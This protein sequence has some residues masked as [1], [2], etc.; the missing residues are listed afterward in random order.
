VAQGGVSEFKLQDCQKK[1]KQKK[2]YFKK[3]FIEGVG[4]EREGAGGG[5][6][7]GGRREKGEEMTQTLY[8]YMSK[9]KKKRNQS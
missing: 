6:G 2:I 4:R 1:T 8:A 9:R 3:P 7:G 5:K